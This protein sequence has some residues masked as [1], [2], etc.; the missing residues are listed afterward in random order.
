ML[1]FFEKQREK[2][3]FEVR[4]QRDGHDYELVITH[5]D[6]REEI[7]QFSD[8]HA[9]AERSKHLQQYLAEDGW[10]TPPRLTDRRASFRSPSPDVKS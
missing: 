8:P 6:G 4:R 2:L 3:H 9:L 7:E 1:W 10:R 5:P